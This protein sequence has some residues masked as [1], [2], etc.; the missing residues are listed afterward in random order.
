MT[1]ALKDQIS[2]LTEAGSCRAKA[3]GRAFYVCWSKDWGSGIP[4]LTQEPANKD[5][6]VAVCRPD[7]A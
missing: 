2:Q 4:Y 6:I 7:A 1:E 3:S 5:R